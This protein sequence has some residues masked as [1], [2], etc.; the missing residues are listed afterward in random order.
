MLIINYNKK[1]FHF[2]DI[3]YIIKYM[4]II[5]KNNNKYILRFDRGEEVMAGLKGFAE[6]EN[7]RSAYFYGL[8]AVNKVKL[9]WYDVE[10]KEYQKKEFNDKLEII[11][12]LGNIGSM[13]NKIII[14]SHGSF[15]KSNF[16]TIAGHIEAMTI[17]ATCE[18]ILEKFEDPISREY[19]PETGLNLME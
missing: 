3:F 17:S 4:K 18:I 12:L 7:I 16:E 11:S 2:L 19:D 6:E 14:H 5:L 1:Y 9:A 8:G 13:E 15:S 10:N